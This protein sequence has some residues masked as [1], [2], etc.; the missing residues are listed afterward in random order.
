MPASRSRSLYALFVPLFFASGF[1]ALV[2]QTIWQRLLSLFGGADVRSA[3]IV[4]TAFM[5]GIGLGGLAGG[6]IADRLS[7]GRRLVA[8][9]AAELAVGLFALGS[10]GLIHGILFLRL[11]ERD[12]HPAVTALLVFLS[13]LWPTF[14]MGASLPLLSRIMTDRVD[15]AADRVGGLYGWNTLG[16]AAGALLSVWWLVR[17]WGFEGGALVAGG[18]SLACA[19][20]A[21]AISRLPLA[22]EPAALS[23]PDA[24][25]SGPPPE[26]RAPD[27]RLSFATWAWLYG[28]AGFVAL[29]LEILWFRVLGIVIKSNAFTFATLLAVYLF[30]LGAGALAGRRLARFSRS[31][32]A[33]FCALQAGVGAYAGLSFLAFVAAVSP[34][35]PLEGLRGYLGA[36]DGL[37]AIEGLRAV[38]ALTRQGGA[39]DPAV[40]GEARLFLALYVAVP[41]YF[42]LTPTLLMGASFPVLQRAVQDDLVRVGRRVGLLQAA[43]ILGSTLGAAVSGLV[44]LR[45]LGTGGT[46]RLLV[47]L[48]GVFILVL[49]RLHAPW[50]SW[51]ALAGLALAAALAF[52]APGGPRLWAH[53]HGAAPSDVIVAEDGTG[54]ALLKTQW[55][56]GQR[57]TTVH[58]GGLGQSALPYGGYHTVLGALPVL[59]HPEPVDVAVIG[60]GSGDTVFGTTAREVTRRIDSI[61]IVAPQIEALR[62]LARTRHYPALEALLTDGRVRFRSGDGRSALMRSDDRYDVIETDALRASSAFSGNLYSVEY[63]RLLQRRLKPGGLA[64]VWAPTP[65]VRDTFASVFPHV[66]DLGG[67][68]FG[69]DRPV[70]YDPSLVRARAR[71]IFTAE[72]FRRAR[73]D[74]DA[75]LSDTLAFPPKL[76]GPEAPRGRADLNTDLFPRDEYR[77]SEPLLP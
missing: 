24:V 69:S 30:G 44:L 77:A 20:G 19:A 27:R 32:A 63:F 12:L 7:P 55:E 4:I 40:A 47:A 28:L 14:F 57:V 37:E 36:Y 64:V 76:M 52:A 60:L 72:R 45:F 5:A 34:S 33:A 61:E 68:L 3:T 46:L 70:P 66:L 38:A 49:A 25:V 59:I 31:P 23:R 74:L 58:S 73:V 71:E 11:G 26:G 51:K 18:V 42:V 16:A 41:L 15:V 10:V 1:A 21:L 22:R 53:M 13:L 39:V 9:A 56:E 43:N 67:T 62:R 48:S 29:S 65:R 35:G 2:C 6:H 50:R 8:F 54:I 17:W 75:A